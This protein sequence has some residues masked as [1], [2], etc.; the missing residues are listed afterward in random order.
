MI[1]TQLARRIEGDDLLN[2]VE[3]ILPRFNRATASLVL[4]KIMG[5]E[6]LEA[7][8]TPGSACSSIR[9]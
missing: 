6:V 8:G 2:S 7:T 3:C 5:S 1:R 9:S 4:E